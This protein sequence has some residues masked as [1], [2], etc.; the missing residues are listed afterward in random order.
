MYRNRARAAA[1]KFVR[2]F[3]GDISYAN[4]EQYIGDWYS[5]VFFNTAYGDAEIERYN[6][7]SETELKAF[8][9]SQSAKII[10][11]DGTLHSD[12]RMYL[13]LHEIGHIT[14]GHIGDG[15]LIT[16]NKILIEFE[17]DAFA[18]EVL[19]RCRQCIGERTGCSSKL[20][21]KNAEKGGKEQ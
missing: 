12:D 1:R 4:L 8:T 18:Y 2:K 6:L 7:Q 9:Y 21:E 16:R 5:I 20:R 11:I 19:T 3:K 17:A 15:M 13:L 14:L 10:F